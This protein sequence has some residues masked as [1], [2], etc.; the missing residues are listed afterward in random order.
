MEGWKE[1]IFSLILCA[2]VS[3]IV[4]Q[5]V[6]DTRQKKLIR[7]VCGVVLIISILRPLST[8]PVENLFSIPQ[9]NQR[10][11]ENYIE[12]GKKT[13]SEARG[14]YIKSACEAYILYK[15]KAM[16]ADVTARVFLNEELIPVSAEMEGESDP[17][18]QMQ[19]ENILT[20]DLGIPKENQKWI[21]NQESN[22]S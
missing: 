7:L 1:Y 6:S 3:A 2:F 9:W 15:A 16:D 13:A 5:M 21:W 14:R 20:E 17:S 11:A 10:A 12:E 22:T 19:L 8:L 18:V 4:L